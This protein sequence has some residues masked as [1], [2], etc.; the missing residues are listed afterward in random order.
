MYVCVCVRVHAQTH[1]HTR[2]LTHAHLF[3]VKGLEVEVPGEAYLAWDNHPNLTSYLLGLPGT[4][5]LLQPRYGF[6]S[7][8]SGYLTVPS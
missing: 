8:N 2:V 1:T 3:L 6:T 4:S 7:E 5:P